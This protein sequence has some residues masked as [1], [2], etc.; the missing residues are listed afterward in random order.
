MVVRH[1]DTRCCNDQVCNYYTYLNSGLLRAPREYVLHG[2]V[3]G[4]D[5]APLWPHP[6]SMHLVATPNPGILLFIAAVQVSP[7]RLLLSGWLLTNVQANITTTLHDTRHTCIYNK[8]VLLF[9][10]FF[11][12][13]IHF[14]GQAGC[15]PLALS[16]TV[17]EQ[18]FQVVAVHEF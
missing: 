9:I 12:H 15:P 6:I 5:W 18:K 16:I 2:L 14:P 11:L 4:S 17:A 13:F 10:F 1:V 7:Q 3:P 8:L